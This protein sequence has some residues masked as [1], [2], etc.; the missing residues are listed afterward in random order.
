MAKHRLG[1]FEH[2]RRFLIRKAQNFAKHDR[3]L[4]VGLERAAYARKAECDVLAHLENEVRRMDKR[5]ELL[6]SAFIRFGFILA[7]ELSFHTP[8]LLRA[9][10]VHAHVCRDP[11]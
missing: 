1:D 11:E 6:N 2:C 5:F 10:V 7:V 8:A 3:R 9:K 4:L